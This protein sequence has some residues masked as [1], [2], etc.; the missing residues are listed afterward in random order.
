[1][2]ILITFQKHEDGLPDVGTRSDGKLEIYGDVDRGIP[3]PSSVIML[4]PAARLYEDM[5][6]RRMLKSSN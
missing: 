5:A 1:M 4:A 2:D 3:K 6:I